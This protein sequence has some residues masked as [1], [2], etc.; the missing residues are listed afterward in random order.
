MKLSSASLAS[1]ALVGLSSFASAERMLYSDSLNP[2]QATNNFSATQFDVVL[3][4]SNNS[5]SFSVVGVSTIQGNITIDLVVSAY[6]LQIYATT[7]DPC[8][9]G[10][11]GLCPMNE[12]QLNLPQSNVP[13][14]AS[15]L[16][17]VPGI[18]YTVPDLDA[19]V[20]V[21]FNSTTTGQSAACVEA[22]LSNGKTVD[23]KAVA[24]ALAVISG[25]A[26]VASAITSGLGH[27]NTAAHVA[28]NA[29][30]LFG[31]FQAQAFI[32]MTAVPLPPVVAS[33]TQ[34]FQWSMGI[35]RV[36][37]LQ[38]IATWYQRST[39][40]K[41]SS[42]LSSLGTTSVE[43]QK[44]SMETVYK[45]MK[46]AAYQ[47]HDSILR[48]R[49]NAAGSNGQ[50]TA[51]TVIVRGIQRVGFRSGIEV[52]NIFLT[53]Y[54]FFMIFVVAVV[55]GVLLFKLFCEL[56]VKMGHMKGEK[57]LD[58]RNG[59]TT[60]LKGIMF[61]M[62]LIGFPQMVVLCFW[63]FTQNDSTAEMVLAVLTIFAML[64]ILA[65]ASSKVIRLARRSISM[66][67]NPA[68][69]LYSDPV[70]LNKWGFLY[71]QFKATAYYFIVPFLIYILAKGL[72]IALGQGAGT[73]QAIGLVVIEAVYLI[74]IC[75]LRPY[76]DKKTNGF[77]IAITVIN[78]ISAVF[79]LVFTGIFD[80]PGI[81]TGV[82]GVIFF[83]YNAVFSTVLLLIVLIASIIAVVA[84]NPDTRYQPMRD[85]RGSFIKSQSHLNHELDALGATARG[86]SKH[87]WTSGKGARIEED[88]DDSWSGGSSSNERQQ[89]PFQGQQTAYGGPGGT[90]RSQPAQSGMP[91]AQQ[92]TQAP[93][94]QASPYE[95]NRGYRGNGNA[96]TA[97]PS[98]WQR[99][100]GYE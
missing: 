24:W 38:D 79:L 91:A 32:G 16:A 64:S 55:I 99:G 51:N 14:P 37:F 5:L 33:W 98:P 30:A 61:R 23:Q 67:K 73:V 1:W 53:G 66:H 12:G 17:N 96:A 20:K 19:K 52:T 69:I 62:V 83:V 88:E 8:S 81:V 31:Y 89:Q 6:G 60:V 84:K 45:L 86:E 18:A 11:T 26:L 63:E 48:A 39:G 87:G 65:W 28:A 35:I 59:W 80:Q 74:T 13:I 47:V 78:F 40:G 15:S 85:D 41:P 44:R 70:S 71:V 9:L 10:F 34:N 56:L 100:A 75:V 92:Q 21:Y 76:M 93:G 2:C 58:F 49:S 95:E 3:T 97:S 22:S 57:F 29:L 43:V 82:M 46:R 27:S 42:V 25:L 90:A 68:Y 77:N 36:G 50:D 54:I 72:F 7:L 4:P 94:Y